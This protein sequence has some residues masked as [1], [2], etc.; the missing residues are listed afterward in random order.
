VPYSNMRVGF[1]DR[2]SSAMWLLGMLLGRWCC[3]KGKGAVFKDSSLEPP[4]EMGGV[5][6]VLWY[7]RWGVCSC[8][9]WD[10]ILWSKYESTGG[11]GCSRAAGLP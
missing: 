7:W 4:A 5:I 10:L 9:V 3:I 6:G 8:V 11:L 2:F 1:H